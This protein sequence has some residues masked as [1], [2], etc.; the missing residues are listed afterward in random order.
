MVINIFHVIGIIG[1]I[2]II[3]GNITIYKPKS[4]R[5]KYTYPL[6]ILGGICMTIYSLFLKDTIF[7]ILQ[8]AFILAAIYGLIKIHQRIKYNK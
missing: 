4:I 8:I 1:L 2:F 7:I 5:K 6:L 3:A